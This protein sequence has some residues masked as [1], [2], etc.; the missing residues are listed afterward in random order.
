MLVENVVIDTIGITV[1]INLVVVA[2]IDVVI[3]VVVTVV[4]VDV[5]AFHK[6][7]LPL[8]GAVR[9]RI[10]LGKCVEQRCALVSQRSSELCV[11]ALLLC[12]EVGQLGL[13]G[14]NLSVEAGVLSS[15]LCHLCVYYFVLCDHFLGDCRD[16][17]RCGLWE[18]STLDLLDFL[19]ELLYRLACLG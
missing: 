12:F 18:G 17:L 16:Y 15:Q 2:I 6:L 5:A 3:I 1:G 11:E 19:C 13:L 7:G 9:L 14:S 8:Y 4:D 10:Q